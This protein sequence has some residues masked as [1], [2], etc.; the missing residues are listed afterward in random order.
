VFGY[1]KENVL[2]ELEK[3]GLNTQAT[4]LAIWKA[5]KLFRHIHAKRKIAGRGHFSGG[6]FK[7]QQTTSYHETLAI[8]KEIS[9]PIFTVARTAKD[10]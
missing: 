9:S 8:S 6:Q 4:S 3:K 2:F 1:Q 7:L 10:Y 5:E